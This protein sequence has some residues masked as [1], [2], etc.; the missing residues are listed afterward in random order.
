MTNNNKG[1]SFDGIMD[2]TLGAI[3]YGSDMVVAGTEIFSVVVA[4]VGSEVAHTGFKVAEEL[5]LTAVGFGLDIFSELVESSALPYLKLK[6]PLS[7]NALQLTGIKQPLCSEV[8]S[9]VLLVPLA[10]PVFVVIA[11][12]HNQA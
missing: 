4:E 3:Q 2:T 8:C 12:A 5:A 1:I 6:N 10:Q 11:A 9:A 7:S